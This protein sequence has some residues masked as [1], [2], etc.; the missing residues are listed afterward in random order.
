MR[1]ILG[2]GLLGLVAYLAFMVLQFPVTTLFGL[3]TQRVPS[4]SL[5]EV[6]GSVLQGSARDLRIQGMEFQSLSWQWRPLGLL[7]GKIRYQVTLEDPSLALTGDLSVNWNRQLAIS[8]LSG[9]LPLGRIISMFDETSLPLDGILEPNL[10]I[11]RLSEEGHLRM[12]QGTVRLVQTQSTLGQPVALG[13]F[14]IE[15]TTGDE[16]ILGVVN[17][18]GGPLAVTGTLTLTHDNRYRFVGEIGIRDKNNPH[19][20]QVLSLLGQPGRDGSRTIDVTG[21]L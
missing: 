9:H 3:L 13:D 2:Y 6:Q 1:R 8:D 18:N 14:V 7:S 20:Q 10:A 19:L 21:T 4:L 11:L 17:D 16:A 5:Q 12:A 15:L